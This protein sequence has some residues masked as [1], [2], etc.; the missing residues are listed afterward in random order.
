MNVLSLQERPP[1][2]RPETHAIG[3]AGNEEKD[4]ITQEE[5][6]ERSTATQRN[7]CGMRTGEEV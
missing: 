1:C 7:K 2:A 5:A 4:D 6:K 3:N